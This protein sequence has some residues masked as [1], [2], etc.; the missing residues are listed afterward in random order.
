VKAGAGTSAAPACADRDDGD[1]PAGASRCVDERLK[2]HSGELLNESG[3]AKMKQ[4]VA[5]IF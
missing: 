5:A 4:L 1:T 2:P 3:G